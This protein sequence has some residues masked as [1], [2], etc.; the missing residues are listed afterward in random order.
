MGQLSRMSRAGRSA[1]TIRGGSHRNAAGAAALTIAALCPLAP[2]HAATTEQGGIYE[3]TCPRGVSFDPARAPLAQLS[4][5]DRARAAALLGDAAAQP[6]CPVAALIPLLN[7]AN[8][9]VRAEAAAALVRLG[10]PAV[11]PLL[12]SLASGDRVVDPEMGIGKDRQTRPRRS[13]Y[14]IWILI[15]TAA[16]VERELADQLRRDVAPQPVDASGYNF[17]PARVFRYVI[18]QRGERALPALVGLLKDPDPKVRELGFAVATAN[19]ERA[20]VAL[21]ALSSLVDSQAADAAKAIEAAFEIGP[22]AQPLMRDWLARSPSADIRRAAA[23]GIEADEAGVAA[24]LRSVESDPDEEVR[25]TALARL[26]RFEQ[27]PAASAPLLA[28]LAAQPALRETALKGLASTPPG[29]ERAATLPALVPILRSIPV[30][31]NEDTTLVLQ[32][33]AGS[34]GRS[35]ALHELLISRVK[36]H[37]A[38][39]RVWETP[40]LIVA[41]SAVRPEGTPAPAALLDELV[42]KAPLHSVPDLLVAV[43]DAHSEPKVLAGRLRALLAGGLDAKLQEARAARKKEG[44]DLQLVDYDLQDYKFGA[45]K[46][47]EI[48]LRLDPSSTPVVEAFLQRFAED[49]ARRKEACAALEIA[50]DE[51]SAEVGALQKARDLWSA[52]CT[53]PPQRRRTVAIAPLI[54]ELRPHVIEANRK[55]RERLVKEGGR[56]WSADWAATDDV[57]EPYLEEKVKGAA[58]EAAVVRAL[59][60]EPALE[61]SKALIDYVEERAQAEPQL[62]TDLAALLPKLG[63][64]KVAI[65]A[66]ALDSPTLLGDHAVIAQLLLR[67]IAREEPDFREWRRTS[68][69]D[70]G[71]MIETLF[72]WAATSK[73]MSAT[74]NALLSSSD[75][76]L[77]LAAARHV[78]ASGEIAASLQPLWPRL[79]GDPSEEVRL[80]AAKAVVDSGDMPERWDEAAELTIRSGVRQAVHAFLHQVAD[81]LRPSPLMSS[82]GRGLQPFPWPPPRYASAAKFG[83]DVDMALLG[84]TGATL[85]STHRRLRRAL[86]DVDPNFEARLFG[87]PGGFVMLTKVEQIDQDGNPTPERWLSYRKPPSA[88]SEY[89]VALFLAP[90]GYYRA[91]AFVFT[92]ENMLGSSNKPLPPFSE[93]A[94]DLPDDVAGIPLSARAAYVLVYSFQRR[95]LGQPRPYNAVSAS[96]HLARSGLVQRLRQR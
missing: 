15:N 78:A 23:A 2:A 32:A 48:L 47:L 86:Q 12:A 93:G 56:S 82:G 10:K 6:D 46:T 89:L 43:A 61:R 71:P 35:E 68:P 67:R 92:S 34:G 54:A 22:S 57:L 87:A 8:P 55:Q 65:A 20:A 3:R 40:D 79:L 7:D 30:A 88:L 96:V 72:D 33:I 29:T 52:S 28:A 74:L 62:A 95:D 66:E 24:L 41:A 44:S 49:G 37:A 83:V 53:P 16:P 31:E 73:A 51:K 38:A 13:D 50:I 9:Q 11:A 81:A 77:R 39:D 91:I 21:P 64:N 1:I 4:I 85:G 59:Q 94:L 76:A 84:D 70:A 19:G 45:A 69:D 5:A 58:N 18:S 90:P 60:S 26:S 25:D 17:A 75:T 27:L 14:V 63:W 36:A 42:D 80:A